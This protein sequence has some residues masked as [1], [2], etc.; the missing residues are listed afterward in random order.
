[1]IDG[2]YSTHRGDMTTDWT[3][4]VQF[5]AGAMMGVFLFAAASI[6]ALGPTHP[7]AKWVPGILPWG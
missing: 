6:P 7:P 5:P 3:T 2:T 4:G 1:M